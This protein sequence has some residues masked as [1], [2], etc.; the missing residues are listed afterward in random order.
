[1]VVFKVYITFYEFFKCT[2]QGGPIR[3]DMRLIAFLQIWLKFWDGID[4]YWIVPV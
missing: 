3:V 4:K 1:M 2:I